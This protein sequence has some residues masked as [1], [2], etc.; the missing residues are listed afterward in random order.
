MSGLVKETLGDE[1]DDDDED[2]SSLP[3]I[4]LPNVS[5]DVL[6]KV[7]EYCKYYQ[8]DEMRAIQTPLTLNRLEE[9]VQEWYAEFV[10]VDKNLLFDLVAAANFM[11]IKPLLDLSCLAVSI[12]IKGKSA[13]ELRQ[14]FNISNEFSAEE[15][16]Q[17]ARD[18][19]LFE[20]QAA[21]STNDTA[22]INS[23][24][25]NMTAGSMPVSDDETAN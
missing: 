12:L 11:D 10:K 14:M 21:M 17:I 20:E 18:N 8:D 19:R 6:G 23:S 16:A 24:N 4:P 2:A 5:A 25:N 13:A 15:K 1:E 7:I 3:D 9:L 22:S